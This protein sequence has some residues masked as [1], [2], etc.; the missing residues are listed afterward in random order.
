MNDMRFYIDK[1]RLN[2]AGETVGAGAGAASAIWLMAAEKQGMEDGAGK[3]GAGFERQSHPGND[4][5]AGEQ[6]QMQSRKQG[7]L[8]EH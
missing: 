5:G 2:T 7:W 3:R 4:P 6:G 8:G 1:Q